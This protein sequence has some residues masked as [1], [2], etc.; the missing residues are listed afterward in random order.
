MNFGCAGNDNG[1][2]ENCVISIFNDTWL[3]FGI[4]CLIALGILIIGEEILG[5][6]GKLKKITEYMNVVGKGNFIA[7]NVS[8]YAILIIVLELIK[9]IITLCNIWW[10][11]VIGTIIVLLTWKNSVYKRYIGGK[12]GKSK[13]V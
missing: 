13:K 2:I 4:F 9:C 8:M 12:N 3:N 5:R 10:A 1:F 6:T 7:F 11:V